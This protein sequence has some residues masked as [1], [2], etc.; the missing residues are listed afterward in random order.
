MKLIFFLAFI[1]FSY[2]SFSQ[3]S[4]DV[5]PVSVLKG[6]D[7]SKPVLFYI[8]GDGGWNKFSNAFV[9]NLNNKGYE[10][11]GLN[12]REYFWHKK[13]AA[14]TAK[15]MS[16]LISTH[17]KTVKNKSFILI[18][19]SFGAD[20]M[21]FVVTH[22]SASITDSLRYIILMSPSTKTDFEVH[23]SELLGIGNSSGESVAAEINKINSPV[24]FVFGDKEDDFPVKD[25]RI[26]NYKTEKLPGGHHYD[27]DPAAVCNIILPY[28]K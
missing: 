12:A 27:G 19:Y 21:P 15:D 5:L 8:S 3:T 18:G 10:I 7:T 13:N 9:Q 25:I 11:V 24:L 4:K 6:R 2:P 1:I 17:M 14:Q 20:V 16:A 22:S 28:L 23:V 26:K